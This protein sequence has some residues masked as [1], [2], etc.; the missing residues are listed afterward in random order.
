MADGEPTEPDK[1]GGGDAETLGD[2]LG[3]L[4]LLGS[5]ACVAPCLFGCACFCG[6]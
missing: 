4:T 1:V 2:C 6:Q 5:P 3:P